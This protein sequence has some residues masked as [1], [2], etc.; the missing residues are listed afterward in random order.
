M[1]LINESYNA[2][3]ETIYSKWK[4]HDV[5]IMLLIKGFVVDDRIN[6]CICHLDIMKDAIKKIISTLKILPL[7]H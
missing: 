6:V 2:A 4:N 1:L 5:A 7:D 3:Y